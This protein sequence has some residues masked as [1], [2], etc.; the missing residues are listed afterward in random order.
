MTSAKKAVLFDC[1][2]VLINTEEIGYK[3]VS[4]MLAEQGLSYT[5]EEYVE[6][7]SG[8]TYKQF[9]ARVRQ[10][11]ETRLGRPFPADFEAEVSRR[12]HLAYDEELKAIS[13][14]KEL[15]RDLRA[16]GIPYAVASNSGGES[17]IAKLKQAGLYEDFAPHIYSRDDVVNAKPAPDMFLLAAKKIGGF[18]PEE[19]IVVEDSV[20]GSM[21]GVAAG[22][23]VIG[24]VGESH[25]HDMEAA[26]LLR[27]GVSIIAT[28]MEQVGDNI[29]AMARPRQ[30]APKTGPAPKA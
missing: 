2:G 27:A 29:F 17:L 4:R 13:G 26:Y 5:R 28:S 9:F 8:I 22:M 6:F 24:F 10:D 16:A 15:L 21:A 3:L 30:R 18:R 23:T 19:C 20:T 1:D 14:V 25:R 12:L 7:L 11:C